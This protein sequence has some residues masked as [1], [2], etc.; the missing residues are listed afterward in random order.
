M[1]NRMKGIVGLALGAILLPAIAQAHCQIPCGIYDDTA[2]IERM[3]EDAN[4]IEKS[5]TMI[6]ELAGATSAQDANQLTRWIM[7][8]EDHAANII[9]IVSEYFLTQKLKAVEPDDEGYEAYLETLADHHRVMRAAMQAKQNT[10]L[11][12]V[13]ALRYAI[14][15]LGKHY[16]IEVGHH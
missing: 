11:E 13:A 6:G 5:M 14:V 1:R 15:G 8:K 4:T 2:R 12:Y 3:L 10:D 9:S 7:N 16:G